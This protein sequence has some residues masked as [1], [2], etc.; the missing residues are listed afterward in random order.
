MLAHTPNGFSAPTARPVPV[1]QTNFTFNE[2]VMKVA[3]QITLADLLDS[4]ARRI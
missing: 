4:G 3:K 1:S 2:E